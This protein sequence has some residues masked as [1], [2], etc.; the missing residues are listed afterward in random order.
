MRVGWVWRRFRRS[1][2]WERAGRWRLTLAFSVLVLFYGAGRVSQLLSQQVV[3]TLMGRAHVIAYWD[4]Q[5]AAPARQKV[6][7]LV[8]DLPGVL[9][10]SSVDSAQALRSLQNQLGKAV[11]LQEV[12]QVQQ[13]PSPERPEEK[14]EEGLEERP[15]EG[16]KERPEQH[17]KEGLEAGLEAGLDAGLV[18]GLVEGL[19]EG[20]LPASLE[21]RLALDANAGS[22]AQTLAKTLRSV[23]GIRAVDTA[24]PGLAQLSSVAF[25][26]S[27][28]AWC[29]WVAALVAGLALVWGP[30][31]QLRRQNNQSAAVFDLLG[32]TPGQMRAP[33]YLA[34][35]AC[36][37]VGAIVGVALL[38]GSLLFV[39]LA[40]PQLGLA[41]PFE[42]VSGPLAAQ[43]TGGA[44]STTAFARDTAAVW[45][46]ALGDPWQ[47]AT[48]GWVFWRE[49]AAA[50][51]VLLVLGLWVGRGPVVDRFRLAGLAPSARGRAARGRWWPIAL[52]LVLGLFGT[53]EISAAEVGAARTRDAV[54]M[55]KRRQE[56]VQAHVNTARLR[57]QQ[58]T[59]AF[60]RLARK[61]AVLL[62]ESAATERAQLAVRAHYAALIAQRSL[63]ELKILESEL[64]H[65]RVAAEDA[66][67]KAGGLDPA[68]SRADGFR[69]QS[70]GGGRKDGRESSSFEPP[71]TVPLL[72]RRPVSGPVV[73]RP[74]V[75]VDA[76]TGAKTRALGIRILARMNARV[77]APAAGRIHRVIARDEGGYAVVVAH[78]DGLTSII[79]GLRFV[80][81][82]SGQQI[83]AGHALGRVGRTLDGAPVVHVTVWRGAEVLDARVVFGLRSAQP[84]P[85]LP[86]RLLSG[87]SGLQ[88][89][90]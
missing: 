37:L 51:G 78:G 5:V 10:V 14:P 45:R 11:D 70:S 66:R 86:S 74:G 80:R 87:L 50:W 30:A 62:P 56:I 48:S 32:A 71:S 55:L 85:S 83:A 29:F 82:Q 21:V 63:G 60:Y 89:E 61:R 8:K 16:W 44:P 3:P 1:G 77:V 13:G 6:A 72:L 23:P 84:S 7:A 24:G 88:T 9:A 46:S 54:E 40:L 15:K 12:P 57:A 52:G 58:H 39:T 81:V 36:A 27:G 68:R 64:E 75:Y 79:S 31:L 69:E 28:L 20:F 73:Q 2:R 41:S 38:A 65:A 42:S 19:E 35:L 25:F 76:I 17:P 4:A 33:S 22:R 53:T 59:R 47:S 67:R 18:A 43:V 34:G 49:V 90:G 26:L